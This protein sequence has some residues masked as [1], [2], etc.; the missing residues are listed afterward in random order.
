MCSS[1]PG[2]MLTP[3]L[4]LNQLTRSLN[5]P[6]SVVRKASIMDPRMDGYRDTSHCSCERAGSPSSQNHRICPCET[7]PGELCLN[8]GSSARE[9]HG[10]VKTGSEKATKMIR[11]L[12]H[13]SSSL[14]LQQDGNPANQVGRSIHSFSGSWRAPSSGLCLLLPRQPHRRRQS[15]VCRLSHFPSRCRNALMS[16]SPA[17]V[18]STRIN[19]QSDASIDSK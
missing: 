12:E 14:C 19:H 11:G 2:Q 9:R 10:P 6:L 16:S 5:P 7:P 3:G 1:P 18:P 8:L 17:P 4:L 13:L 15:P